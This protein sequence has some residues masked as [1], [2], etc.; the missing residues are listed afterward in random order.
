MRPPSSRNRAL[1]VTMIARGGR[2]EA[3]TGV[4]RFCQR[5]PRVA[6]DGDGL[7]RLGPR[8]ALP[9]LDD[10]QDGEHALQEGSLL[11]RGRHGRSPWF[12]RIPGDTSSPA[13]AAH[14]AAEVLW[15]AY[16]RDPGLVADG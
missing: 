3:P 6:H 13:I 1:S 8:S 11:G 4:A 2:R 14:P 7:L 16:G 15:S 10:S 9:N 5:C 12:S